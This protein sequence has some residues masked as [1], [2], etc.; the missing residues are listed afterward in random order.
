MLSHSAPRCTLASEELNVHGYF[1]RHIRFSFSL[2]PFLVLSWAAFYA[3]S[4]RL[5]LDTLF[6]TQRLHDDAPN[7]S[8]TQYS[9]KFFNRSCERSW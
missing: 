8:L 3:R 2:S 6:K 7:E 9:M 5:S 1:P 4:F